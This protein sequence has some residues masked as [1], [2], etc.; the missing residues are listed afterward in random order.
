LPDFAKHRSML[1]GIS[2]SPT[3]KPQ[4][5]ISTCTKPELFYPGNEKG[6]EEL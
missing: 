3:Q 4:E 1:Q 6:Q 5:S 2:T